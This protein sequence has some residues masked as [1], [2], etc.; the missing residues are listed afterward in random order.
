MAGPDIQRWAGNLPPDTPGF[1]GRTAELA[2]ITQF[3]T[4]SRLVTL[5]GVRGVGKTRLACRV[6][7][8]VRGSLAHGAWFADLSGQSDPELPPLVVLRALRSQHQSARPAVEALT[9]Y[10]RDK[11]LLL[12]LDAVEDLAAPCA[13]LLRALLPAAEGLRV[14]VT[15]TEP[16]GIPGERV[17]PVAPLPV[18][19]PGHEP[20]GDAGREAAA[21]RLLLDRLHD[22]AGGRAGAP[23][24]DRPARADLAELCR[25]AGGIPLGIE[26]A[27]A[28]LAHLPASHVLAGLGKWLARHEDAPG[29]LTP[30]ARLRAVLDWTHELCTPEERRLWADLSVFAPGFDA[31]AAEYVFHRRGPRPDEPGAPP[32]DGLV[33]AGLVIAEEADEVRYRLPAA[34]AEHGRGRLRER[35]DE[36]L[37]LERHRDFYLRRVRDGEVAWSGGDQVAWHRRLLRDLPNLRA[38]L[39]FCLRRP[40]EH[41]AGLLMACSL[42]YLWLSAGL[43]REGRHFLDRLLKVATAPSAT[44]TKALWVCGGVAAV[45]GDLEGARRR[46][47]ECLGR[48]DHDGDLAA[49]GYGRHVLGTIALLS[50]E[51]DAAINRL[52]DAVG[53]HRATGELTPGLLLGL[54]QLAVLYDRVG[55]RQLARDLLA[56]ALAKCNEA[57][58][59]WARG[60][61]VQVRGTLAHAAGDLDA[62][63]ADA[64]YAL[65]IKRLFEDVAGSAQCLELLACVSAGQGNAER[66]TRLFGAARENRSVYGL[67]SYGD[68]F[69]PPRHRECERIARD[70]LG[71]AAY[72][73]ALEQG[74]RLDL[75]EAI[76]YALGED[77][78]PPPGRP[79]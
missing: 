3:L 4:H 1:I 57:G 16:L 73:A 24:H 38:A 33:R 44:R 5:T 26:L 27:A 48:A 53:R 28:R 6:A 72:A 7:A 67:A 12:V 20:G 51:H 23:G 45:Q 66:A 14:L 31:P 19:E 56:E 61:A 54:P 10:L 2:G 11:R 63:W 64:R 55:E 76:A 75:G 47:I 18:P 34:V 40:A 17:W 41:E 39:G 78:A 79:A 37:V 35:G 32:L 74:R 59:L 68:A 42:W 30:A 21:L 36:S 65:R 60:I 25:M 15:S 62:A 22:A 77:I 50:G 52:T 69:D 13:A 8:G 29:A 9:D 58:E 71:E 46:A 70:A 43:A 49:A